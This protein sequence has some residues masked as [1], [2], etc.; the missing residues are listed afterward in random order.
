MPDATAATTMATPDPLVSTE[1]LAAAAVMVIGQIYLLFDPQGMDGAQTTALQAALVGLWLIFSLVHAAL[2]RRGRA[3]IAVAQIESERSVRVGNGNG[4]ELGEGANHLRD[5]R[6]AA[7]STLQ[8]DPLPP[9]GEGASRF[10]LYPLP[11]NDDD[12]D[13]EEG[14]YELPDEGEHERG[15]CCTP[16]V[17]EELEKVAGGEE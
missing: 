5:W 8:A 16:A 17:L 9:P 1:Q 7:M 11:V 3:P 2:V 14:L 10:S 6:T 4:L 13:E 12:A 15:D